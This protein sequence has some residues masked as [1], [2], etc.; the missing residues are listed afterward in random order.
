MHA[1]DILAVLL[2]MSVILVNSYMLQMDFGVFVSY[3]WC[4]HL[5]SAMACATNKCVLWLCLSLKIMWNQDML[6]FS[7]S[8]IANFK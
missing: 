2:F 5:E 6:M 3:T 1:Q 7:I 4:K 8:N